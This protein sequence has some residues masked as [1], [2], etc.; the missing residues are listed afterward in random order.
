MNGL[1]LDGSVILGKAIAHNRTL[2][3]LNISSNRIPIQGAM[4]IAKGL[5]VNDTLMVLRVSADTRRQVACQRSQLCRWRLLKGA[6]TANFK[7][8]S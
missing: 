2:R 5:Y 3:E 7:V 1:S 8:G 4:D 6:E